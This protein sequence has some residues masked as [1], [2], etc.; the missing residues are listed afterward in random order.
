MIIMGVAILGLLAF[1]EQK[2]TKGD[3]ANLNEAMLDMEKYIDWMIVDMQNGTID[4]LTAETYVD[5]FYESL[6]HLRDLK[7][8]LRKTK[9]K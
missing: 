2:S 6:E 7:K 3:Y 1:Q 8:E 9:S 4:H 5:N